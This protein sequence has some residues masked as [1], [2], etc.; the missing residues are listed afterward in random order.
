M[1]F[2]FFSFGKNKKALLQLTL[3]ERLSD[4]QAQGVVW[5]QIEICKRAARNKQSEEQGKM[6]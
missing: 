6:K 2:F 5:V 4:A 1:Q 3:K